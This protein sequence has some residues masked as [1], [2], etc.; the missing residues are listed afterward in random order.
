MVGKRGGGGFFGKKETAYV[1]LFRDLV[2][3]L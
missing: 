2:E 1:W 3:D